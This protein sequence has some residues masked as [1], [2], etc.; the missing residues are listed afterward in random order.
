MQLFNIFE[1]LSLVHTADYNVVFGD[2]MAT[3]VAK[4]DDKLSPFRANVVAVFGH[5]SH[6]SWQLLSVVVSGDYSR[7]AVWTKLTIT[8][9]FFLCSDVLAHCRAGLQNDHKDIMKQIE[10]KLHELHA[11]SG[12]EAESPMEVNGE[13]HVVNSAVFARVDHVDSGSPAAAA[14]S[15]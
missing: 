8:I 6:R 1:Y 3:T 11:Q 10:T 2:C 7:Q 9:F 5:Y 4:N 13:H 14:V 15:N 12:T